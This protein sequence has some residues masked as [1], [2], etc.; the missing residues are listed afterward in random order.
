MYWACPNCGRTYDVV[1]NEL[2]AEALQK[3]KSLQK[4]WL[5]QGTM[6]LCCRINFDKWQ[7]HRKKRNNKNEIRK[8]R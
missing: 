8:K 1:K 5:K 6:I 2:T 7:L 4:S 3:M